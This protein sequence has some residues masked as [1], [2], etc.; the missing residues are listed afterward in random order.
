M[1]TGNGS[2]GFAIPSL[3]TSASTEETMMR[4]MRAVHRQALREAAHQS[5]EG[6]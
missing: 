5:T 6:G 1:G 3:D 4:L 2:A